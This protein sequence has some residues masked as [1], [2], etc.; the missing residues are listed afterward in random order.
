MNREDFLREL[1]SVLSGQ[2]P[3]SV[4]QDNI[5]YYD[6][7]ILNEIQKGTAEEETIEMLGSPRLIAKTIIDT[8]AMSADGNG[9]D[10]TSQQG[11][12]QYSDHT[13]Q[14][15]QN[16]QGLHANIDQNGRWDFRYGRFKLNSWYAMLL[17]FIILVAILVVAA[18]L[19][20]ALL[21]ILIPLF[22]VLFIVSLIFS[23][24]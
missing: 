4:I 3:E 17:L 22:L 2:V 15:G 8:Y 7:Y 18:K 13:G 14:D 12:S 1:K 16:Q 21:P 10:G 19:F 11:R 20:I 5:N 23:R 9:T 24:R 6:G